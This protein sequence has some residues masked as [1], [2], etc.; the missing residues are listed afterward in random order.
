[1]CIDI[2][3]MDC[4]FC[5]LGNL[6]LWKKTTTFKNSLPQGDIF[7]HYRAGSVLGNLLKLPKETI[8]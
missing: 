6:I 3:S 2:L 8:F 1:M 7:N 5:H 4:F